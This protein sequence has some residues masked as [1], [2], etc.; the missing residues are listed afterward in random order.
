MVKQSRRQVGLKKRSMRRRTVKG[1][2]Y[3]LKNTVFTRRESGQALY[4]LVTSNEAGNK[5]FELDFSVVDPAAYVK[6]RLFTQNSTLIKTYT[7]ALAGAYCAD[8]MSTAQIS[9]IIE[10]LFQGGVAGAKKLK[11]KITEMSENELVK[12]DLIQIENNEVLMSKSI[13]RTLPTFDNFLYRLGEKIMPE[14]P[15]AVPT[16]PET[17]QGKPWYSGFSP[18]SKKVT[19]P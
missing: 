2:A 6:M 7:D 15:S 18:F 4:K 8:I 9:S 12:F 17:N 13:T 1:G 3:D 19:N 16:S 5:V 10:R 14:I 11:L